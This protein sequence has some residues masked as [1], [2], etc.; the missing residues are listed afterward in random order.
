MAQFPVNLG[1]GGAALD[2]VTAGAAQILDGYTGLDSDGDALAGTMPNH[3]GENITVVPSFTSTPNGY[4]IMKVPEAGYYDTSGRLQVAGSDLGYATTAQVLNTTTFTSRN[5]IKL[6]GDITSKAAAT[7]NT[8][9]ADQTISAGQ[10]LSGAQTIKGVT[11]SNLSAA[12]IKH[13]V[14]VKVGDSGS[15]GRIASV[16]GSFTSDG[17]ATAAQVRNGYIAYSQGTKITGMLSIN[18]ATNFNVAQ[19]ANN[20]VRVTCQTPTAASG[21]PWGGF[22][23]RGKIGSYPTSLNDGFEV[24]KIGSTGYIDYTST[25]NMPN[26]S[27]VYFRGWD[28]VYYNTTGSTTSYPSIW[29][30]EQ[31]NIGA[32]A[33]G[34][35]G[36][37]TISSS[38]S[39]TLPIGANKVVFFA[40]GAGGGTPAYH[41]ASDESAKAT[42]GAGG[43]YTANS[44]VL[45]YSAG[46]VFTIAIGAGVAGG[47]GGTTTVKQ[48]ATTLATAAGGKSSLFGLN[49]TASVGGNGGSGGGGGYNYG[50]NGGSNGNNG[51]GSST[52]P[53][54]TGTVSS[55]YG[56]GQ[57]TSTAF[58]GVTYSGGGGGGTTYGSGEYASGGSWGGGAGGY[59]ALYHLS[60]ANGTNGS[61]GGAGGS[62]GEG[63]RSE[64]PTARTGGSG[65]VIAHYYY[66]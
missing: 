56:S 2:Q 33:I 18:S 31:H 28:Y 4:F 48:G 17:T 52:L 34:N 36:Y 62:A 51:S 5:G 66:A 24:G 47:D 16:N 3:A 38:G 12:N 50:G 13:G 11:T 46:T 35:E 10:Y 59:N 9:G 25:T 60:G 23:V 57:G 39:W 1:G 54:G 21:R 22:Y 8:S 41:F 45:S 14:T 37:A 6:T 49:P 58:N 55:N 30:G 64:D 29:Y 65:V 7:Y 43:G 40:V 53:D 61:G 26:G 32:V 19:T 27:T 63:G 44:G 20:K 15:A 42:G